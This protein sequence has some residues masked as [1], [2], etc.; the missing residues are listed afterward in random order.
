MLANAHM[1][2]DVIGLYLFHLSFF[3]VVG[4]VC[5]A[6]KLSSCNRLSLSPFETFHQRLHCVNNIQIESR[7]RN[8][9]EKQTRPALSEETSGR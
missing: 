9:L 2:V 7:S 4:V 3:I 1:L 5:L 6:S 8:K